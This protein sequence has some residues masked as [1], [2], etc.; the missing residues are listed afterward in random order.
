MLI[1]FFQPWSITEARGIAVRNGNIEGEKN[2]QDDEEEEKS[3]AT[4]NTSSDS[5]E[6]ATNSVPT[7][8]SKN[9]MRKG[10][11]TST[12]LKVR[13]IKQGKAEAM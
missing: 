3:D 11:G 4:N 8:P 13:K 9:A 12:R 10:E 6:A 2:E 7:E 1:L 5:K